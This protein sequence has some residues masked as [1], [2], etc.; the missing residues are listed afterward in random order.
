LTIA[1]TSSYL[2][3]IDEFAF[4]WLFVHQHFEQETSE[5][6]YVNF[7]A[8]ASPVAELW[9]HVERSADIRGGEVLGLVQLLRDAEIRNFR[10]IS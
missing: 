7:E 6:P 5:S 8:V 9:G 2:F 4:E 3:D 10:L 1:C